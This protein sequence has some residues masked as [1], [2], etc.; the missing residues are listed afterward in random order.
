MRRRKVGRERRLAE[1]VAAHPA[2]VQGIAAIEA[3]KTEVR[4][5]EALASG[6]VAIPALTAAAT[7]LIREHD[8]FIGLEAL[9]ALA[10]PRHHSGTLMAQH[11]GRPDPVVDEIYISMADARGDEAHQD[12]VVSRT[13]QLQGFNL[14]GATLLAEDSR[15]NLVY[16]HVEMGSQVQLLWGIIG[17]EYAVAYAFLSGNIYHECKGKIALCLRE[18]MAMRARKNSFWPARSEENPQ[19]SFFLETRW[20]EGGLPPDLG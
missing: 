10:N 13:F 18:T 6:R 3:L 11:H 16:L 1:K 17:Y 14:Q 15:L 7:R 9:H 2:P 8:M 4:L 5:V 12:F 20:L 19:N